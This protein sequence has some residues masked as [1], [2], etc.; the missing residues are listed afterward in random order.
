VLWE[1]RV[2]LQ[3]AKIGTFGERAEDVFYISDRALQPLDAA[4][5]ERLRARLTEAL[6]RPRAAA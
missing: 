5:A 3:A 2:E 1:E 6:S 4:A